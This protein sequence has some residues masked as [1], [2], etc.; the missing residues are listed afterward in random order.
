MSINL[1]TVAGRMATDPTTNMVND[2][3]CT[4]FSLASD[5]KLK[6]SDGSYI[7]NFYRISAWR[8]LGENA[9]KYLHKG[10]AVTITGD[11]CIREY[12]DKNGQRRTAVQIT[13]SQ[14]EYPPRKKEE[15]GAPAVPA[16]QDA[17]PDDDELPF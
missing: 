13:A 7:T 4:S 15:T 2:I 11:V 14:I 3:T 6:D 1:I 10:D 17:P 16:V 9:A 5:S 8:R 12:T